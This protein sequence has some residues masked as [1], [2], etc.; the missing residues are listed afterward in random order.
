MADREMH[1]LRLWCG[2]I[3]M[4]CGLFGASPTFEGS[5]ATATLTPLGIGAGVGLLPRHFC[6]EIGVLR[7]LLP[8]RGL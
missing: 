3:G 4:R 6:S 1:L 7:H 8:F 5:A 2:L